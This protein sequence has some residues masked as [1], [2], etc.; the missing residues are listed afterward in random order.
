LIGSVIDGRTT[1]HECR[2]TTECVVQHRRAHGPLPV[3][4]L[5]LWA[6]TAAASPA[7][8]VYEMALALADIQQG[9]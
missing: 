9:P 4:D 7:F 5:T 8:G 3:F 1:D 2:K 6:A